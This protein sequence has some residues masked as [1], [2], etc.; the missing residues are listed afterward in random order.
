MKKY[1]FLLIFIFSNLFSNCSPKTET[2]QFQSTPLIVIEDIK[3]S[4]EMLFSEI[5]KN[6]DIIQ[7]DNDCLMGQINKLVYSDNKYFAL[8][9]DQCGCLCSFDATGK[10]IKK[11]DLKVDSKFQFDGITEMFMVEGN[12]VVHDVPRKT[13]FHLNENLE[14]LKTEKL[15]FQANAIF[16]FN[17]SWL[18]FLNYIQPEYKHDVLVYSPE[19]EEI[20]NNFL[21]IRQDDY[22]YI[23]EDRSTF[24]LNKD[25]KVYFSRAFNDTIYSIDQDFNFSPVYYLDFGSSK[26][27][28]DYLSKIGDAMDLMRDFK[29]A[30]YTFLYGNLHFTRRGDILAQ[31]QKGNSGQNILIDTK[32]NEAFLFDNFKDDYIT[33]LPFHSPIFSN[34]KHFIFEVSSEIL[35]NSGSLSEDI[36]M[37]FNPSPENNFLLFLVE[38]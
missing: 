9:I 34:E 15:P 18:V 32:K 30:K 24:S 10:L 31:V 4:K 11:L 38:K 33:G 35:S 29:E 36:I 26:T 17:S 7:L 5:G 14:V 12:L 28:P 3:E 37:R 22:V 13:N 20:T 25:G 6:I 8:D 19:K 21:P 27:P 16:P 1:H 23:Y 2:Q